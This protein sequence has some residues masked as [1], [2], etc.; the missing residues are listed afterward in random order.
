M[1]LDPVM[2]GAS[3][4]FRTASGRQSS[5]TPLTLPGPALSDMTLAERCHE[6]GDTVERMVAVQM[7]AYPSSW[8]EEERREMAERNLFGGAQP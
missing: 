7:H 3:R 2:V 1:M 6:L 5:Y 8:T 4:A